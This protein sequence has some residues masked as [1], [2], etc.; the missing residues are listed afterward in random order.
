MP[1]LP[2]PRR[3]RLPSGA[4]LAV[5]EWRAFGH[6]RYRPYQGIGVG[7]A[8]V[9]A[10]AGD[11]LTI[12]LLLA[13]GAAPALATVIGVLPFTFSAAQLLVP[14]LLRR[15]DG[16][17]RGVTVAILV[18]GE[19]RGFL[20][21]AIV[22]LHVVGVLPAPIAILGVAA[23]MSL[24]GAASAI[25]GTNLLAWYGAIL[26]EPERRFVAPRVM[27]ITQGLGAALL[28]PVALG[29]Q[30]GLDAVG[31]AVYA[32]VFI[33]AGLA[34]LGE[35][36]AVLRL[37][38]PGRVRVARRGER[39][40][41]NP[42]TERFIR[43]IAIAAAGAGFGP[44]LSIY[45]ISILDAPASFAILL[46]AVSSGASLVA[47]TLVGGLLSRGSA[48]RTLRLSFVLRGGGILLALLAFPGNPAA[49]LILLVVAVVV[50][51]G[52]AA[53][54]LAANERLLRL[55][56]GVDLIGAQSR[57]VAGSALGVTTR[58]V[59][60][61]RRPRPAADRARDPGRLRRLRDPHDR[62]RPH[63]TRPD[64]TGRGLGNLVDRDRGLQRRRAAGHEADPGAGAGACRAGPC[65]GT[66][67]GRAG[68]R[69][70]AGCDRGDA[71]RDAGGRARRRAADTRRA[72]AG[73]SPRLGRGGTRF[74]GGRRPGDRERGQGRVTAGRPWPGPCWAPTRLPAGA[75]GSRRSRSPWRAWP[76]RWRPPF[77]SPARR[78]ARQASRCTAPRRTS[79]RRRRR[80]ARAS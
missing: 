35:V 14:S 60:L 62:V 6:R 55:T 40:P 39:P 16:N 44:Y 72:G 25:G 43:I 13:L 54:T 57:F 61:G 9:F 1:E 77:S 73:G 20:L 46:S 53:G 45:A 2:S 5:D 58:A 41:A 36:A 47:A 79:P 19:T 10:L 38:Y 59:R 71:R 31:L 27:G 37:R 50:S 51:A 12:P 4:R 7:S 42:E 21:A 26:L 24:G 76:R 15:T 52:A 17:L 23:V 78:R 75:P 11:G 33:A 66:R 68:A 22:L 70:R 28:L 30:A 34:G 63:A 49:W 3:P 69:A 74:A 65:G 32:A 67:R 29:V 56:G 18:V 8:A 64:D 80:V 48:S